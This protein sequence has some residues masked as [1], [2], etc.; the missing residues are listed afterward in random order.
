MNQSGNYNYSN[1]PGKVPGRRRGGSRLQKKPLKKRYIALIVVA[2]VLAA[3]GI[4]Y[5]VLVRAPK[6]PQAPAVSGNAQ[7]EGTVPYLSG[8][9]KDGMYT[10][11]ICGTDDGN[12][13]T[14][15]IMVASYNV[16]DKKLN[17]VSVPRDTMINVSWSIKK[18]NASYGVGGVERLKTELARIMGFT[19]DYY[20]KIDL[21]A[22]VKVVDTIGGVDF[23]VP[24]NMD[25]DDPTQNLHIHIDKGMQHLTGEQ[26]VGVVRFRKGYPD[27]DLGRIKTQQAFVKAVADQTLQIQNVAK[28]NQFAQIFSDYVDTDLSVGNLIWFAQ[29]F[30]KL[31]SSDIRFFTMPNSTGTYHNQSYVTL[32]EDE[33]IEMINEYFNPYTENVTAANLD[34]MSITSTGGLTSSTGTVQTKSSSGGSG[35]G[36]HTE[37]PTETPTPTATP[38]VTFTP[39]ATPTPVVTPKPTEQP[40]Q[41]PTAVPTTEPTQ[42]PAHTPAPGGE[43]A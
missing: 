21:T 8:S 42:E 14:D 35:G 1:D 13:N 43:G 17:I 27:A 41:E 33:L 31:G 15:T 30:M 7:N 19:V 5:A 34:I 18:I 38:Q 32:H 22:F 40:T 20:I 25:Y 9:R 6:V 2:A 4:A 39:T 29:E 28:I 12:G 10:F 3:G 26:A 16:K 11:L 23:D 24:V 37:K 36:T